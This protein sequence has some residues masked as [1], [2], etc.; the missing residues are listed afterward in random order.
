[1]SYKSIYSVLTNKSLSDD[2]NKLLYHGQRRSTSA[3]TLT[4]ANIL[5]AALAD[6]L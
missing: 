4:F 2:K 5:A 3:R 6:G 1:M